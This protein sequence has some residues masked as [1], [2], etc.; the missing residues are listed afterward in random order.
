MSVASGFLETFLMPSK[1]VSGTPYNRSCDTCTSRPKQ[2][3][4][5]QR[6]FVSFSTETR[7]NAA[8]SSMECREAG[9]DN[10]LQRSATAHEMPVTGAPLRTDLGST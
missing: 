10:T 7:H 4:Q 5:Q 9:Y 3:Q 6:T 1:S 8:Y 2:Q